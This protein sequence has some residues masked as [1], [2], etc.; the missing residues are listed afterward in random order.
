MSGSQSILGARILVADDQEADARL[1]ATMLAGAG[2]S[3]VTT[4]TDPF[5]VAELHRKHR[6]DLVIL[7]VLMPG[8]DGFEVMAALKA[9]DPEDYLPI[10]V[11]TAEP[12]HMKRALEAGARDFIGK[13]I[14]MAELAA[15]VHNLLELGMLLRAEKA[16]GSQLA[17][18]LD[19][20]TADLE[21]AEGRFRA[22]VEQSIAGIY[23]I[24]GGRLLY[25]TPR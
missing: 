12:D 8:M 20:R 9:I 15:R 4:T 16:R 24:D 21:D 3:G 18:L 22:L 14:R 17:R 6:Y 25:A 2:Y 23:I 11:V 1:I 7:D 13:P 5:A 19:E 10:I